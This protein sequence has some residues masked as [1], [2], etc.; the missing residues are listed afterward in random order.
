MADPPFPG[1]FSDKKRSMFLHRLRGSLSIRIMAISLVFLVLP[2]L[3]FSFVMYVHDYRNKVRDNDVILKLLAYEK[4]AFFHTFLDFQMTFINI[5][6]AGT[7]IAQKGLITERFNEL[8]HQTALKEGIQSLFYLEISAG[9]KAICE[10]S[11][12]RSMIGQEFSYLLEDYDLIK[13]GF[14]IYIDK[15]APGNIYLM[16]E[17]NRGRASGLIGLMISKEALLDHLR[18]STTFSSTAS[19]MS[20]SGSVLISTNAAMDDQ[21]LST[22]CNPSTIPLTPLSSFPGEYRFQF[23]GHTRIGIQVP[24]K[25]TK[26]VLFIDIPEYLSL[27]QFKEYLTRIISLFFIIMIIGGGGMVWV[28]FR[29]AKPLRKLCIVMQSVSEGDLSKRFQ[30]DWLGFEINVVGSI[31]N[32]MIGSLIDQI[33]AVRYE[34]IEKETLSRE[35]LIGQEIQKS[36]LPKELPEFTDVEIASGF[37]SAKE[38]GGDFYDLLVK[39]DGSKNQLMIS[40]ADTSGKGVF[41]CFY[42]LCVRS[43]L[44]SYAAVSDDLVEIVSRTNRL[45]CGDTGDTG[46][47]VTAWV[48]L[49]DQDSRVMTYT[50]CGHHPAILKKHHGVIKKL[51]TSGMALGVAPFDHIDTEQI[52]LEPGDLLV[53]YTDGVVEA[54]NLKMEMFGEAKLIEV[55]DKNSNLNAQDLVNELLQEVAMFAEG[56]L[57]FDDLTLLVLKINM[58]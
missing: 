2:L 48:A 45:F 12:D 10:A 23:E 41:A 26:F 29:I 57:Q 24:I 51:T 9:G 55:I 17:V 5:T 37:V 16:K 33:E 54:H 21:V 19:L 27:I 47:F 43:M 32:K 18:S 14:L 13:P 6:Y 39:T 40:V 3:C 30:K 1:K 35:L 36:I 31:F 20:R 7:S 56:T 53:L 44:R 38:V 46:V 50:S 28:T 4:S 52:T 8:I 11:S 58:E 22:S 49:F 15:G 34:R 25:N 42:S